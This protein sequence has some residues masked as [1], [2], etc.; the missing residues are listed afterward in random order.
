[1]PYMRLRRT[2]LERASL[3]LMLTCLGFNLR[4]YM[5]FTVK[6]IKFNEW[7][8]PDG[9][10]PETFKTSSAKRLAN[11]ER[12]KKMKSANETARDSYKYKKTNKGTV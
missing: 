11:R 8:A 5:R 1:M 6:K 10:K 12:K 9:T 7:K 2:S 3:E 4:K